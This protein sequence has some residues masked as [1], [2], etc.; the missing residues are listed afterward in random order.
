[1]V[2]FTIA[3]PA[4]SH[5]EDHEAESVLTLNGIGLFVC[6]QC[7]FRSVYGVHQPRVVVEPFTDAKGMRWLRRRFQDPITRADRFVVDM[8]PNYAAR[9]A[10]N[11]LSI[12]VGA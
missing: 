10:V 8:D 4:C 9:E 5:E 12:T 6:D 3:C 7:G 2:N 1:M 11:I